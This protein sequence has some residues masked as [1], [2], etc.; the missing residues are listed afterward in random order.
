MKINKNNE[1]HIVDVSF[2]IALILKSLF[3]IGEVVGGIALFFLTPTRLNSII[4]WLTQGEI[5]ESPHDY[6]VGLILK[7]GSNF[8]VN[9]QFLLA[10]YLLSHGVIKLVTLFLLWKK[11]LWAYPLSII[12]FV[13]FIV[14]QLTEYAHTHS[15]F[16]I[17]VTVIDV[18]MI[19]LTI[20]EYRN[21]KTQ[22]K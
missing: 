11:I 7:F 13:G 16:M 14:Y 3:A 15:I 20:L 22:R 19:I 12:V 18:I 9:T 8:T 1:A 21:I 4:S 17:F 2:D 10:F 6:V 5:Q